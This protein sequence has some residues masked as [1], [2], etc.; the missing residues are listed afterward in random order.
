MDSASLPP[1]EKAAG[2]NPA[3]GNFVSGI[4]FLETWSTA[5]LAQL[6]ERWSHDPKVVSSI[7]TPGILRG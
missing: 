5:G 2:S 1:K 3:S 6:V 4:L 7:L